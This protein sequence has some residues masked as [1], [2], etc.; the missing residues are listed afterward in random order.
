MTKYEIRRLTASIILTGLIAVA[1]ATEA[2]RHVLAAVWPT[3]T[4]FFNYLTA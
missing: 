4:D 2:H 1:I 3:I